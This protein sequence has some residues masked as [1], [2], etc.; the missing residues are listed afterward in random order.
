MEKGKPTKS[1]G[2]FYLLFFIVFFYLITVDLGNIIEPSLG[3]LFG[4]IILFTILPLII[5]LYLERCKIKTAL[6]ELG[7]RKDKLVKSILLGIGSLIITMILA[8]IIYNWEQTEPASA[9]WNTVMFLEAF[10]EEFLFR[11]VLLLY[12]WKITE[13]KVAYATSILAFILA[14]PQ[15]LT[16]L[17][18][19]C[20][21]TQGILLGAVAHKTK[22]I[23]EPWISHGLNR[24]IPQILMTTVF[25]LM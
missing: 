5:I 10:N 13:L 12:L 21:A 2:D 18:F 17:S 14:H 4:K 8:L 19:I 6:T 9:Y 25:K 22:N 11:G 3:Y 16:S 23:I 7:I 1:N 15:H 20:V 24:T